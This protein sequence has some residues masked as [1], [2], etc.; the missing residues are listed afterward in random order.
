MNLFKSRL[1]L[2]AAG[3]SLLLVSNVAGQNDQD[4]SRD[5]KDKSKDQGSAAPASSGSSRRQSDAGSQSSPGQR[6]SPRSYGDSPNS[7][8]NNSA[9]S[10]QQQNRAD[11][12]NR[13]GR[14]ASPIA[15][16]RRRGIGHSQAKKGAGTSKGAR[17]ILTGSQTTAEDRFLNVRNRSGPQPTLRTKQ[18]ANGQERVTAPDKSG[19]SSEKSRWRNTPNSLLRPD[20]F[21]KKRFRSDGTRQT[22]QYAPSGRV[23]KAVVV[24]R[25]AGVRPASF[26]MA[27]MERSAP[28]KR[29][30]LMTEE[31]KSPRQSGEANNSNRKKTRRS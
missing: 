30:N 23:Q 3:L 31:G 15:R 7:A 9:A 2:L 14:V 21:K 19:K 8:G 28:L 4:K 13:T 12:S 25:M 22:V 16:M 29:S 1:P 11:D 18:I 24:E 10:R 27:E 5:K 26:S 17:P 6:T 20:E